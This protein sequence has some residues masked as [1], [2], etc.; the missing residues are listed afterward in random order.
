MN[1]KILFLTVLN[2]LVLPT[3]A[4]AQGT[5][6]S[7]GGFCPMIRNVQAVT[8]Q[9]GGSIVIIGWVIAGILYLTAGGGSRMEVAK[10]AL[11]AAVIGTLL[12]VL[13]AGASQLV[14]SALNLT[15]NVPICS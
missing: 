6:T 2:I 5:G 13:A 3:I 14:I 15:G 11:I 4:F 1:K 12:I 7:S 9:V 10:K 8:Y